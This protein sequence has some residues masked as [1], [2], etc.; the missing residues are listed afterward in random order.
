MTN[1][2]RIEEYLIGENG[3]L[4]SNI[5]NHKIIMLSGKW[6][7]GKTFFWKNKIIEELNKD[8]KIPNHYISLYG[9][10]S[11]EEIENEIFLKIFESVDSF[12][13]REKAVKLS[14][15]VVNLL[16]SFSS[17]VNFFGVNLDISKVSDKPFDKLEEILKNNKLQK[18]V[19]YLNSGAIICFDDFERKSKDIDLNDLFGFITQLTLNFSCKVVIILNDDAFEENDK[20]IFSNVKE[21]S[22]SKYLKYEPTIKELFEIIFEN[23]SYKKLDE[24]KELIL[25]TIQEADILNARIYIQILDNLVEWITNN[26]DKNKNTLRSLILVNINFIL[27]HCILNKKRFNDIYSRNE[28]YNYNIDSIFSKNYSFNYRNFIEYHNFLEFQIDLE[29]DVERKKDSSDEVIRRN[30]KFI[31]DNILLFKSIYFANKLDIGRE[32][33]NDTFTKINKFVETGIIIKEDL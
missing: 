4:K 8:K 7:S 28:I 13:S 16:S 18:A 19:E 24:Y 33:D 2:E 30:L 6:G 31:E 1:Q 5:S 3:Y 22:V 27:Y 11:I 32:I 12:E 17:A 10:K 26:E 29:S 21:K 15:N 25:Q 14:K 20:T 9:K 23:K